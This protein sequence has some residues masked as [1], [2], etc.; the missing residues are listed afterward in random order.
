M[1]RYMTSRRID[2]MPVGVATAFS[3]S[4]LD[5]CTG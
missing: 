2:G 5:F 1:I 3:Y 4:L